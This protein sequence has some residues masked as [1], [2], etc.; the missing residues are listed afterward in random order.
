MLT[1]KCN[2]CQMK[3]E[4]DE[5]D[6]KYPS[7]CP[8]CGEE[9]LIEEKEDKAKWKDIRLSSLKQRKY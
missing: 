6:Q 2:N 4:T 8:H 5:L 3:V 9:A 7:T 1:Y